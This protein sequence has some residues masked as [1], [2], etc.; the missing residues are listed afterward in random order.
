MDTKQIAVVFDTNSYRQLVTSK[1][2][3][4]VLN[5]IAGIKLLEKSKS[6]ECFGIM[7]VGMEMLSNL[8]EGESG[9]NL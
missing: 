6:I 1:S 5:E 8:A 7:I 4:E 9:F 2:T 3:E